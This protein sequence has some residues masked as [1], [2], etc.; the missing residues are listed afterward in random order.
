MNVITM[1]SRRALVAALLAVA[2]AATM[3]FASQ[4][5]ADAGALPTHVIGAEVETEMNRGT[6]AAGNTGWALMSVLVTKSRTQKPL[7][8]IA[9]SVARNDSGITVP[10]RFVF[11]DLTVAPGG[12]AVTPTEF[13]NSGGGVYH[14]RFAPFVG[15]PSC[16]WLAGDY[17]Y[18]VEVKGPGGAVIGKGLAKLSL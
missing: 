16:E 2:L 11:D 4:G 1:N 14:I 9:N 18:E 12:C 7:S 17:V 13:I 3:L 8:N 10:A 6:A 15:N 5:E